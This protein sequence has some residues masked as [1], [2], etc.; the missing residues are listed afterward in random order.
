VT[1]LERGY[2]LSY[3]FL[4]Q[5]ESDIFMM[6]ETHQNRTVEVYRAIEFPHTWELH[7]TLISNVAAFD[8]TLLR[9]GGRYWL[10]VSMAGRGSSLANDELFLFGSDSPFGPWLPHPQNPIVS[11]VRKA[12]PAGRIIEQDGQ[13]IRPSQDCSVRYGHKIKLNRID[14]LTE[15]EYRESEVGEIAPS[16]VPGIVATHTLSLDESLQVLDGCR[17]INRLWPGILQGSRILTRKS[18]HRHSYLPVRPGI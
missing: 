12:R 1:V 2:H 18:D 17:S 4:F 11:D 9:Y 6:P 15:D 5:W 13:L 8:P 3:P 16:W 7:A 14:V 10:F